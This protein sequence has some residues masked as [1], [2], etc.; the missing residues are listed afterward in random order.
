VTIQ[1]SDGSTAELA[2]DV[3]RDGALREHDTTTS[4]RGIVEIQTSVKTVTIPATAVPTQNSS[5]NNGSME[6]ENNPIPAV[7][8]QDN[9][10]G[11][12]YIHI[13]AGNCGPDLKAFIAREG[14]S[15]SPIIYYYLPDKTVVEGPNTGYYQAKIL[16]DG[17][18]DMVRLIPGFYTAYL[19]NMN[20]GEFETQSFRITPGDRTDIWFS[21]YSI[22]AS[23]RGCAG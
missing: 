16:V 4:P 19:P 9:T 15:V 17:N 8:V 21:G 12:L 3:F 6:T 22:A 18:S 11:S 2:V 13:R 10:L 7:S 20:G 14:T 5:G 1:K 23:A